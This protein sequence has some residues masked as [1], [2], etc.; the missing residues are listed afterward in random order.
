MISPGEDCSCLLAFNFREGLREERFLFYRRPGLELEFR[1]DPRM[2][3]WKELPR[4]RKS[5][6]TERPSNFLNCSRNCL[7]NLA[8]C[9]HLALSTEIEAEKNFMLFRRIVK[10]SHIHRTTVCG[11]SGN[12]IT[13]NI[14]GL[15]TLQ[16]ILFFISWKR[17]GS[18][19]AFH[20]N[21]S[22]YD[23]RAQNQKPI[24]EGTQILKTTWHKNLVSH[25]G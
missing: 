19:L 9:G 25:S 3:A 6:F 7:G 17:M 23:T 20:I 1:A 24:E 10:M 4:N 14:R 16:G 11:K 21:N 12:T 15:A 5:Y 8:R 13:E 18:N 2:V 22:C